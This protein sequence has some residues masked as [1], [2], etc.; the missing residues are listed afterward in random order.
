MSYANQ[1][2]NTI[3]QGF[4]ISNLR[5]LKQRDNRIIYIGDGLSDL[6]AALHANYVFATGHLATLLKEEL[7]PWTPFDDFLDIR[8]KLSILL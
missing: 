6:E 2:G 4:K 8:K 1:K 3:K 5:W 7:V